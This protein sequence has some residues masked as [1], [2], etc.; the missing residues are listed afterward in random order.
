M[1]G[2]ALETSV[3]GTRSEIRNKYRLTPDWEQ[4]QDSSLEGFQLRRVLTSHSSPVLPRN[5]KSA[6]F[7]L[8]WEIVFLVRVPGQGRSTRFGARGISST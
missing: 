7:Q 3:V 5:G 8:G 6:N 1:P 2:I 4:V